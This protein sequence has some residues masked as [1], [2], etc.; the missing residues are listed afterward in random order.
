VFTAALNAVLNLVLI[1]RFGILG[2]AIATA[3][4]IAVLNILRLAEVRYFLGMFPY[5]RRFLPGVGLLAVTSAVMYLAQ[6][7]P[8]SGIGLLLVAGFGSTG[9]FLI[10]AWLFAVDENDDVLLESVDI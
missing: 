4:A 1:Q 2:A 7:L 8:L 6:W 10:G 5:S 9:V 3:T